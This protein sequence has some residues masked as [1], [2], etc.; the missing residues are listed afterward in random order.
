MIRDQAPDPDVNMYGVHPTY[1]VM[2]ADGNTHTVLFLNSNAQ[3]ISDDAWSCQGIKEGI[4]ACYLQEW[5]LTPKPA[6]VYRT[7]GGVLDMYFFLG[8]SPSDTAS[9]YAQAV[10]ESNS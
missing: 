1:T 5:A 7:I 10:G 6:F 2:E 8:P 3:V 9:Q 4:K